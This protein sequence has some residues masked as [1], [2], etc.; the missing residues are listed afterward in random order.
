[1]RPRR[2]FLTKVLS[3]SGFACGFINK[4]GGLTQ[5]ESILIAQKLTAVSLGLGLWIAFARFGANFF[6]T[7]AD[8]P[9]QNGALTLAKFSLSVPRQRGGLNMS[10]A[11]PTWIVKS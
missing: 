6:K 9:W 5:A 4:N 10:I 3:D 7:S 1:M 11:Y 8:T 2:F